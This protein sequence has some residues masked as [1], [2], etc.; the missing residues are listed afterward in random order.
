[1]PAS[2][3]IA[4]AASLRATAEALERIPGATAAI[5]V[6]GI[7]DQIAVTTA[8]TAQGRDLAAEHIVIV[9]IGGAH[10]IT[11]FLARLAP[12]DVRLAGL[13]D[14][15]EAP[16]FQQALASAAV[17][18]STFFVCD[19]D[20]EEELIRAVTPQG[21]LTLLESER[22]LRPFHS[23]Q[24]Q[25]AWRDRPL[26][27]QLYRFLRSSSRRNLRY[28]HLLTTSAASA[29]SLPHPLHALLAAV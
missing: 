5:L 3:P 9:P 4:N 1:M 27:A 6:E 23:F 19:R 24:R 14:R 7:S 25:P 17:S 18:P 28:A 20:L 21:V 29:D 2:A 11:G 15:L 22:D 16:I 13:C 12:H 26:P 10:A 8:A